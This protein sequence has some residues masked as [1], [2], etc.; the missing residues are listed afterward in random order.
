MLS[1]CFMNKIKKSSFIHVYF[2]FLFCF[3][4]IDI[5]LPPPISKTPLFINTAVIIKKKQINPKRC[6]DQLRA[7]WCWELLVC[8]PNRIKQ[9]VITVLRTIHP[10]EKHRVVESKSTFSTFSVAQISRNKGKLSN[11][12]KL[13]RRTITMCY[14]I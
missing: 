13:N 11:K 4:H 1:F 6:R 7:C 9:N 14:I 8:I 10:R 12:Q 2:S 3:F 5:N